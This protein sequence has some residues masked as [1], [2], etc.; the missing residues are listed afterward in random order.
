MAKQQG[1]AIISMKNY[2]RRGALE[3]MYGMLLFGITTHSASW[4]SDG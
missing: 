3:A 1:W 4:P 2:W